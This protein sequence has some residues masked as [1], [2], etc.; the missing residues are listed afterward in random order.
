MN[1]RF[2][3]AMLLLLQSF[4]IFCTSYNK[5]L[6]ASCWYITPKIGLAPA[7]FTHRT[8]DLYVVP[9]AGNCDSAPY[10]CNTNCNMITR[11]G[12]DESLVNCP[13]NMLEQGCSFPKFGKIFHQPL[14]HIG[15]E[16]GYNLSERITWYADLIYNR[17]R[18]K[19]TYVHQD[20]VR[21]LDGCNQ[22]GDISPIFSTI[23][24]SDKYASL[25][26]F[27]AYIGTRYYSGPHCC[28]NMSCF[29]GLKFGIQH[30]RSAAVYQRVSYEVPDF[31]LPLYKKAGIPLDRCFT[32]TALCT[33]TVPSGGIQL[34]INWFWKECS[35]LVFAV[36]VVASSG[37][38][39]N[40]NIIYPSI[41]IL[42]DTPSER[43]CIE[44]E[45]GTTNG[46]SN[47]IAGHIGTF[48]QFP[49][50]I[51]LDWQY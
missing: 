24:R 27:S 35:A 49:I 43:D 39:T 42:G 51:G 19:N 4:C 25:S 18:G 37:I 21:A 48:I 5:P 14:L 3:V 29:V 12:G 9:F 17:A 32:Q 20:L 28:S 36:E 10:G 16:I 7:L 15:S 2:Y 26:I 46:N 30:R 23:R 38:R 22:N 50:W 6:A 31:A 8:P 13:A 11:Q 40:Q 44:K 34:G 41:P 45:L 1:Q 33:H 47:F